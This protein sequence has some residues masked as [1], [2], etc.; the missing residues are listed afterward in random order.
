MTSRPWTIGAALVA[1]CGIISLVSGHAEPVIGAVLG[2]A[3]FAGFI[4]FMDRAG[5]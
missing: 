4:T 3:L 2:V 5:R 1:L